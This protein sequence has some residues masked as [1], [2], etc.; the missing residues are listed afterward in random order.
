M[1]AMDQFQLAIQLSGLFAKP[2]NAS[3]NFACTPSVGLCDPFWSG[4]AIVERYSVN[5]DVLELSGL[6]LVMRGI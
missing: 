5:Y 4:P 6:D 1:D 2:S 3:K